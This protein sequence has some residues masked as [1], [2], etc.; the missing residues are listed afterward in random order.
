MSRLQFKFITYLFFVTLFSQAQVSFEEIEALGRPMYG[1][2]QMNA[3]GDLDGDGD[4]DV[5]T[6]SHELIWLEN[7]DGQGTFGNS[8]IVAEIYGIT[9]LTGQ[10]IY[11][12]DMD[13]DSDLDI[14]VSIIDQV[15]WIENVDGQGNFDEVHIIDSDF[16]D[17]FAVHYGDLD[18]DG[19]IDV[20][21]ANHTFG[22]QV[23]NWYENLDGNGNMGDPLIVSTLPYNLPHI[24]CSDV[25]DDGDIDIVASKGNIVWYENLDG[26]GTFS[27]QIV[28]GSPYN[29]SGYYQFKI[30]D[31][32][33]DGDEDI[34]VP[35]GYIDDTQWYE[36]F[37][38]IFSSIQT[39]GVYSYDIG[40]SEVGDFDGDGDKDVITDYQGIRMRLNNGNETFT[41]G[42]DFGDVDFDGVWNLN[43]GDIDNDGDLDIL[44]ASYHTFNNIWLENNGNAEFTFHAIGTGAINIRSSRSSDLDNDGD[45]DIV[46]GSTAG[47][48]WFENTNGILNYGIQRFIY[49]DGQMETIFIAD[50]DGDSDEDIIALNAGDNEMVWFENTDGSGNF[51]DKQVIST[52]CD[53]PTSA[54]MKDIDGDS[55]LDIVLTSSNDNK[56]AWYENMDG[57]GNFS[58]EQVITTIALD[59]QDVKVADIDGDGDLDVVVPSKNDDKLYWYENTNG[60][61]SFGAEHLVSDTCN[62]IRSV[63]L[64]DIDGDGDMDILS[65]SSSSVDLSWFENTDGSGNFSAANIISENSNNSKHVFLADVDNDFDYDVIATAGTYMR[66]FENTDGQ[67]NF[68]QDGES[69]GYIGNNNINYS[70]SDIDNDG[71]F[72]ILASNNFGFKLYK[73]LGVVGNEITGSVYL[74]ADLNGCQNNAVLLNDI[75]VSTTNGNDTFM[76]FSDVDGSFQLPVNQGTFSTYLDQLPDF[77]DVSP[78]S[79]NTDFTE[80]GSSDIVD[81]CIT[82]NTS[83]NDLNI[84]II[85]LDEPRPGFDVS[86]QLV[87]KNVG[88]NILNGTI[89]YQYDNTKMQFNSASETLSSQTANTLNFDYVDLVPFE[90]R[91]IQ[92]NFQIFAPPITNLDDV[93]ISLA[94]IN[95]VASDNTGT[96][97]VFELEEVV[98]GSYDPNDITCLQGD[99]VLI[100]NADKYLHYLIR[101]QNT[102]TADAINVRVEQQLDDKL[103][104]N[105]IEIISLSHH[106]NV[107]ISEGN[108]LVITFNEIYLSSE[109]M[110]EPES[111]GFIAYKIKPKDNV[112]V[113]DIV[114]GTANIYF[115]FNPPIITN[116]A[117]TEFVENL[118]VEEYG[119]TSISIFPN[120]VNEN[121]YIVNDETNN[122]LEFSV[123]NVEGRLLVSNPLTSENRQTIDFSKFESGIYFLTIK[124]KQSQETFKVVKN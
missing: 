27:D 95:P 46:I 93:L 104:W 109:S 96:D 71:D 13:G 77:Y 64:N 17:V 38:G 22:G 89:T 43:V 94:T 24:K 54:Q 34:I 79:H 59:V 116:T 12:V 36:N 63:D 67:G 51:G 70:V 111:H 40:I 33:D 91:N 50:I 9:S 74:D 87:Y 113:G 115:D 3:L 75:M 20:I 32:D 118:S 68:L 37:G 88:T 99:T 11:P 25:D 114:S 58:D 101:F 57:N 55:D 16:E 56:V 66:W 60:A 65:S 6:R 123:F 2:T 98:I 19:D 47:I 30:T 117:N 105:S 41:N 80:T 48:Y 90:S 10:E 119:L 49:I 23:L 110:N 72:D 76:T 8:K 45:L 107:S 106:G 82:P 84:T 4:L 121:L 108:N 29:S 85:P 35:N 61:G 73:N 52:S 15:I 1:S 69:I 14:L 18:G 103:E 7:I 112:L 31:L 100:G 28:I 122:L 92:L 44:T 21:A 120:P 53:G 124:T 62:S 42:G 102:G 86:Y 83:I 26:I 78:M 81:F 39:I 5:I 97:N